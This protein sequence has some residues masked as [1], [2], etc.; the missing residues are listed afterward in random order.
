MRLMQNTAWTRRGCSLLWN[1]EALAALAHPDEVVSLREFFAMAKAW[2][3]DLPS[4]D[5]RA[6]VVAGLEGCLD[7]LGLEDAVT[8]LETDLKSRVLAFQDE[9]ET[10]GA[11]VFWLPSGRPR[12][13][14]EIGTGEYTWVAR[15]RSRFPLGR[16][17]WA[18]AQG[19]AE[20]IVVGESPVDPDGPAWVGLYHPR[21]S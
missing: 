5:G 2:P 20:R 19:D 4:N 11:L 8:W 18:G 9:Y 21:I 1:P 17:L 3:E 14:Y 6:L 10:D 15:G 7:A 13:R 16:L 12:I